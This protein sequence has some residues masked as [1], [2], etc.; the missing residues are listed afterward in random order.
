[1]SALQEQYRDAKILKLFY[2]YKLENYSAIT[3]INIV[4]LL[5][6]RLFINSFNKSILLTFPFQ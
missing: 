1:M 3:C 6:I 4:L 5:L 2:C